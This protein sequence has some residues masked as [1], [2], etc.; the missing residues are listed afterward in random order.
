MTKTENYKLKKCFIILFIYIVYIM[1]NY[2]LYYNNNLL[3]TKHSILI[4]VV[5]N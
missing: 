1:T 2:G 4:S 5:F 3:L